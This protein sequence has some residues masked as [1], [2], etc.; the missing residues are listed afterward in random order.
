MEGKYVKKDEKAFILFIEKYPHI[1]DTIED[2]SKK[3]EQYQFIKAKTIQSIIS[4]S[5]EDAKILL[6]YFVEAEWVQ[7][8][9]GQE[10]YV[11]IKGAPHG[12]IVIVRVLIEVSE[13]LKTKNKKKK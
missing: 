10:N 8:I 2:L 7:K 3:I 1:L 6:D 9:N 11:V 12:Q 5:K 13:L 4:C